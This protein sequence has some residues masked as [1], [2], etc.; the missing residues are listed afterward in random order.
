MTSVPAS[1]H[2]RQIAVA[3]WCA[4]AFGVDQATSLPQ[5]GLRLLEE[6]T[7]AAQA[8]GVS[9]VLARRVIEHV[10]EKQSGDLAQEIGGV[11]VTVLALATAAGES[12]N[13]CEVKECLRIFN[14]PIEHFRERNKAKN[15]AG[16]V[17]T[18]SA[19]D[20]R[21]VEMSFAYERAA[22]VIESHCTVA[23]RDGLEVWY[24]LDSADE[25]IWDEIDYLTFRRLLARDPEHPS[26]VNICDEGEPLPESEAA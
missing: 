10:Y 17:A 19:I 22:G 12:A 8:S 9:V 21:D 16:L 18:D 14:K 24:D 26:W 15:A 2:Q 20:F 6:A 13:V 5:R 23:K 11:G 1:R 25:D 4:Q 3:E 7:E